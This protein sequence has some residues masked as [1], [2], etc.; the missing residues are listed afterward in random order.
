MIRDEEKIIPVKTLEDFDRELGRDGNETL[1]VPAWITRQYGIFPEEVGSEEEIR[2]A[3][4]DPYTD[5]W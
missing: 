1:E 4:E 2:Q 3:V 5:D